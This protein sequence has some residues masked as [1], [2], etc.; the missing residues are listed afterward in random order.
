MQACVLRTKEA[1]VRTNISKFSRMVLFPK[2][3]HFLDVPDHDHEW[4]NQIFRDH[5]LVEQLPKK[6]A[7]PEY[8]RRASPYNNTIL[9]N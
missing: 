9:V 4:V 3:G 6:S 8:N 2:R 5:A 7:N 1:C